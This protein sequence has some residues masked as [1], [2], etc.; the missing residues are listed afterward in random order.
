M[1]TAP[2]T[3]VAKKGSVLAKASPKAASDAYTKIAFKKDVQ[4]RANQLADHIETVFEALAHILLEYESY[5]VVLDEIE[6]TLDLLRNLHENEEYFKLRVGAVAAFLPRN[7]PL[8]AFSCFVIVPS[9]MAGEVHFRIPNSMRHFF[10]KMLALL[11]VNTRFPNVIVSHSERLQFLQERTA[12]R[13]NPDTK[14]TFPVTDAVIFTGTSLH[15]E[16]LRVVFDK[17]TL[18]ISNGSGHNPI[19]VSKDA[20]LREAIHAVVTLQLYN[21][22]QDCAAPNSILVHSEIYHDF[23]RMLRD[24]VRAVRIG[25]YRDRVNRVGPIS[26]PKDLVRIQEFLIDNREWLD[27][28]TRGI[29]RAY[30]AIL[31]P[32]ILNKPLKSG[33]N[34]EEIF[35]PVIFVQMY[36]SDEDLKQYFEDPR[37]AENAMYITVYGTSKYIKSMLDKPVNGKI[38]HKKASFLHD[39]HLHAKGSERGTQPYGGSGYGAS[40]LT[41]GGE[42]LAMP[43]LPQRDIYERLAKPL[44]DGNAYKKYVTKL[45]K[46]TSIVVKDVQKLMRLKSHSS[47]AETTPTNEFGTA[48]IDSASVESDRRFVEVD[49]AQ[50]Y[51]LLERPNVDVISELSIKDIELVRKLR[52]LV[53]TRDA[54][55][56]EDFETQMYALPKAAGASNTE[57]RKLQSQFFKLVYQLLF[58]KESGPRLAQFLKDV[59]TAKLTELLDI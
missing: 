39:N 43:T 5:E 6:R 1:N 53:L 28:T 49:P 29:I 36:E 12:L 47:A 21:Q 34:Y 23:L 38:I 33:G 18:F 40:N 27:P 52:A 3:R 58:A 42:T 11:Q 10:P 20:N 15:A 17:R 56:A 50:L 31:E 59:D 4:A 9:L 37:Y 32:T 55:T 2:K 46:A 7:Q 45:A 44:L 24:E 25:D 14:E 8:Y 19:V 16:Q 57:N 51:R 48:Y 35:A 22:G 41:I 30:D 54:L 13:M 26:N